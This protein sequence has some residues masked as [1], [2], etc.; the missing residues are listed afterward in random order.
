MKK[1]LIVTLAGLALGFAWPTF[2]QEQK[3]VA[4]A[5]PVHLCECAKENSVAIILPI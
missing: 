1:R 5:G 3:A 2:A 4:W